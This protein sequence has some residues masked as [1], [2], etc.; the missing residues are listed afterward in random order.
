M[1]GVQTCAL[2]IWTR[3]WGE[4]KASFGERLAAS[5]VLV[6]LPVAGWLL[7]SFLGEIYSYCFCAFLLVLVVIVAGWWFPQ[8]AILTL[9]P[10]QA[11]RNSFLMAVIATKEN[12]LLVL[13]YG[14][15]GAACLL[16]WP[17][18]R[19]CWRC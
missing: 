5:A 10:A 16:L 8:M 18:S 13:L 17:V 6:G 12:L 15:T 14:L 3:F 2:P 7:G 1:T 11:L 19:R 4:F 9:S